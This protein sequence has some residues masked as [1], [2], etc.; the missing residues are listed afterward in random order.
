MAQTRSIVLKTGDIELLQ[1]YVPGWDMM[2]AEELSAQLGSLKNWLGSQVVQ[3]A[4]TRA[5]VEQR[6]AEEYEVGRVRQQLHPQMRDHRTREA[7]QV[8]NYGVSDDE[9]I[10]QAGERFR[11]AGE[12]V[13]RV[14]RPMQRPISAGTRVVNWIS[15]AIIAAI[16]TVT[17]G[18]V[19]GIISKDTALALM[20]KIRQATGQSH[21]EPGQNVHLDWTN[22][23]VAYETRT[24]CVPTF[25][26]IDEGGVL[27]PPPGDWSRDQRD[28]MEKLAAECYPRESTSVVITGFKEDD[29]QLWVLMHLP[30]EA[31]KPGKRDDPNTWIDVWSAADW[32][33][34]DPD[35]V[36]A[37]PGSIDLNDKVGKTTAELNLG[38]RPMNKNLDAP[39]TAEEPTA[40]P[41]AAPTQQPA[42][43]NPPPPPAAP[44]E[45][46]ATPAEQ[47]VAP[48]EQPA[49]QPAV[50]TDPPAA[51]P[52]TEAPVFATQT[53]IPT[54]APPAPK[55]SDFKETDPNAACGI[56]ITCLGG[57]APAKPTQ[58]PP[59]PGASP[60][61]PGA[62]APT[63]SSQASGRKKAN[64]GTEYDNE[65]N[66]LDWQYDGD[67]RKTNGADTTKLANCQSHG[68]TT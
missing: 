65:C 47:P 53:P 28:D 32:W 39:A 15:S 56:Y 43:T 57:R 62:T 64:N 13:E 22:A 21:L 10:R 30:A 4:P 38:L 36:K 16:L 49:E 25:F 66:A 26:A 24:A 6:A 11:R 31:G 12:Y 55:P 37:L 50:A 23:G 45:Q 35:S 61:T 48:A 51:P 59:Q 9:I 42:P 63:A 20:A 5:V 60:S 7:A 29:D 1:E 46:P 40:T 3:D 34:I 27:L 52:A 68:T 8:P 58:A 14:V 19:T 67:L 54:A 44:A 33:N 17:V 2:D 41:T 18:S